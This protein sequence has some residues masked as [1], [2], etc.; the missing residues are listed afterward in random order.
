MKIW[1]ASYTWGYKWDFV[2]VYYIYHPIWIKVGTRGIHKNLLCELEFCKNLQSES[3]IQLM[4]EMYF[5][6]YSPY[7]CVSWEKF[8]LGDVHIMVFNI[9]EFH[10]NQPQGGHTFT[11][12]CIYHTTVWHFE[13][14]EC[15]GKVCV[16][17]LGV[18]HLQSCLLLFSFL[19]QNPGYSL[20][21]SDSGWLWVRVSG[22]R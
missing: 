19:S 16:P 5:Y 20:N 1:S 18:Y 2:H 21:N 4:A 3:S 15:L 6:L 9:C 22:I 17:C 13:S 12:I 8:C 10:E 14:E 11:S 7:F